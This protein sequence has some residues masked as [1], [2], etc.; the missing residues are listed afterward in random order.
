[1]QLLSIIFIMGTTHYRVKAFRKSGLQIQKRTSFLEM[2]QLTYWD[3]LRKEQIPSIISEGSEK[4][5]E[6]VRHPTVEEQA[7]ESQAIRRAINNSM[8]KWSKFS[9]LEYNPPI[10][11]SRTKSKSALHLRKKIQSIRFQTM[12]VPF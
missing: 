5:E 7:I 2:E 9:F 3:E 6:K 1:M 11:S 12:S 8:Q 10:L 4:L